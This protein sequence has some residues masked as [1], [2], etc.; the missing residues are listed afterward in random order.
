MGFWNFIGIASKKE[1]IHLNEKITSI[2]KLANKLIEK[3]DGIIDNNEKLNTKIDSSI[4][5]LQ[6]K[7]EDNEKSINEIKEVILNINDIMSKKDDIQE[8]KEL[9]INN[10]DEIKAYTKNE[11]EEIKVVENKMLTKAQD[12]HEIVNNHSEEVKP[13]IDQAKITLNEIN[14]CIKEGLTK[15]QN[16]LSCNEKNLKEV[17]LDSQSLIADKNDVAKLVKMVSQYKKETESINSEIS[18]IEKMIRAIWVNDIAASL[19]TKVE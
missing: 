7:I 4:K 19:E 12:I 2:E 14:A 11:Y 18:I 13:V 6:S 1:I 16:S 5:E 3:C 17:I 9:L 15:L 10:T 8:F